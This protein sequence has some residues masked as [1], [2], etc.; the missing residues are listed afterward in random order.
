MKPETTT[1]LTTL[2]KNKATSKLQ[3]EIYE[4]LQQFTNHKFFD[5]I[6]DFKVIVI[7]EQGKEVKT[8]LRTFLWNTDG[9]IANSAILEENISQ[10]IEDESIS[11]M[12][13]VEKLQQDV[14]ELFNNQQQEY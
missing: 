8:P 3:K 10:Y 2:I 6:Y 12:D 13:K 5:A 14:E 4:Y 11:F 7:D 9:H 1:D